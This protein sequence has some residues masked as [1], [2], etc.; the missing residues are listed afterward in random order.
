VQAKAVIEKA[1]ALFE[2]ACEEDKEDM[3]DLIEEIRL[4]I[5][6]QAEERLHEKVEELSEI[7]FFMET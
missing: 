2:E 5:A 6:E 7:I 4:A 1:Q 3:V